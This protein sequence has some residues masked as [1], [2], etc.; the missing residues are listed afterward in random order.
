M[1]LY[2]SQL[3]K[4]L[5][6]VLTFLREKEHG[7]ERMTTLELYLNM[8]RNHSVIRQTAKCQCYVM[9]SINEWI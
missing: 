7:C 4:L 5:V 8:L 9:C 1:Y 2:T 3:I 6:F